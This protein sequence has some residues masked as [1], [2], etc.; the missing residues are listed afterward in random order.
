[1]SA[2]LCIP[3]AVIEERQ[4]IYI[5]ACDDDRIECRNELLD[6][7]KVERICVRST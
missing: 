1:M 4:Y 7:K 6:I 3:Q 5:G 2:L